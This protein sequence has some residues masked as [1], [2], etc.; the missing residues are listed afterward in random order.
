MIIFLTFIQKNDQVLEHYRNIS[1]LK[2]YDKIEH[3]PHK[4]SCHIE[5]EIFR[6]K[7]KMQ[8]VVFS[9]SKRI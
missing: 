1:F 2:K 8:V 6:K 4:K 9:E 3:L 7:E 5:G